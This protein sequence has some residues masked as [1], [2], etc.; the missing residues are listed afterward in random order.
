MKKI[1]CILMSLPFLLTAYAENLTLEQCVKMANNN[2]PSISQY[3][4][5]EKVEQFNLSNASK[6]WLPQGAVLGQVTWQNDVAAWPEQFATMLSQ[7]GMNFPGIDKTQY[8]VGIDLSQQIWDGGTTA[9]NKRVIESAAEV[10]RRSFD[11]QIYDV[12]G[13]VQDVYFGILFLDGRIKSAGKS[14]ALVDSTLLQVRSMYRNGVAMQSDCDQIEA[15]L[16][17]LQ[18]QK[19]QLISTRNSYLRVLGI[20]IGEPVGERELVLPIQNH[21][22]NSERPQLRLFDAQ[23]RRITSQE[24]GIKASLMPQIGAFASGYYG[25]PGFNMFKNMQS[26]DPSFNYMVGVKVSWNFGS[27]YTRSNSLNKLQLQR[28]LIESNRETF[29]FN[30]SI[31]ESEAS[32]KI[33]SMREVMQN[34]ERIVTLR[35][36]V[37]HAAQSQLRYGVID[38]T[39]L[40]AKITDAELAENDLILHNIELNK[41]IYNLNH[42][43]NK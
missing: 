8:K 27:L 31:A 2:Y 15:K 12:E 37:L 43:Q 32:A 26:R 33:E 30:N 7:L 35:R 18:Q 38:A 10:E 1:F 9:A 23:L 17:T 25:Y 34:D 21:V 22:S 14:I 13:R 39:S 36:N 41:A 40:L 20:F 3:G 42:I 24:G 4:I 29:L 6:A 16:L 28:Q 19:S 5:I 11:V